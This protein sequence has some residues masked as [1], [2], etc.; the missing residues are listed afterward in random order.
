MVMCMAWMMIGL[1]A[2]AVAV[3][4]YNS[5]HSS[6]GRAWSSQPHGV[7]TTTGYRWLVVVVVVWLVVWSGRF[8][9]V[10]FSAQLNRL[11]LYFPRQCQAALE[12]CICRVIRKVLK[13]LLLRCL[14]SGMPRVHLVEGVLEMWHNRLGPFVRLAV[15]PA[16]DCTQVFGCLRHRCS[17]HM[18]ATELRCG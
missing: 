8:G 7:E 15:V 2:V 4:G 16:L 18:S 6:C 5:S 11:T 1:I 12:D 9:G 10:P 14:E 3:V 13:V 17:H